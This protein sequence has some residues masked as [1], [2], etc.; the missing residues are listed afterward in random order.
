MAFGGAEPCGEHEKVDVGGAKAVAEQPFV[1][2]DLIVDDLP[3]LAQ[4][5]VS[6]L[7]RAGFSA[8]RISEALRLIGELIFVLN[9]IGE[10]GQRLQV[11]RSG[12]VIGG[13]G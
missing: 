4:T 3:G 13:G 7:L 1:L 6:A 8:G 9:R 11:Q 5:A 10:V 12:R 2:A